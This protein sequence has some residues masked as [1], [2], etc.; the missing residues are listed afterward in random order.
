MNGTP[1]NDRWSAGTDHGRAEMDGFITLGMKED[2]LRLARL[3]LEQNTVTVEKFNDALNAIQVFADKTRPWTAVVESAYEHLSKREKPAVRFLMMSFYNASPNHE[4][5]LRL[6]PKRFTGKFALVE[7]AYALEATFALDKTEIMGTLARC[8]PRAINEADH[9]IMQ[10][11][12]L[13]C[14]AE[15]LARRGKWDETIAVLEG[16]QSNEI[17]NRNAVTAIVE[18]HV[19]RALQAL[20]EGFKLIRQFNRHF[21]PD[22]ET[23]MPGNDKAIQDGAAREFRRLQKSLEQIVSEKRQRKL[24][25]IG[26]K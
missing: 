4:A 5:V 15:Y 16:V 20:R 22:A 6:K 11:R 17:F 2:A 8:L 12:L 23:I 21:D 3:N 24:G 19:A 25:L 9:P 7:L 1:E 14:H 13:L 26:K 10:A 18:V